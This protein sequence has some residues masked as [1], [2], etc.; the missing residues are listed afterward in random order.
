ML[1]FFFN[2]GDPFHHLAPEPQEVGQVGEADGVL[3]CV[4]SLLAHEI[5]LTLLHEQLHQ[6]LLEEV[7]KFDHGRCGQAAPTRGPRR[8]IITSGLASGCVGFSL[9]RQD[10]LKLEG[11]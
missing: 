11:D 9:E 10:L 2:L 6:V 3:G 8:H 1:Y 7:V 5:S 4:D